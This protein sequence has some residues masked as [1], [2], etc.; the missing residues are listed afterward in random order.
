MANR[1]ARFPEATQPVVIADA[2]HRNVTHLE[3]QL[4]DAGVKNPIVK[5]QE[6]VSLQSFLSD[7]ASNEEPKPCVLFLDPRM[8]GANGY[9]PVRWIKGQPRLE[10][11]KVVIFSS[12][13]H[14]EEIESAGELGVHL[15]L[16]KN[17]DVSSLSVI[18]SHL[19]GMETAERQPWAAGT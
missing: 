8:P 19:C 2:D 11:I 7:V 12:T 14:P 17:P 10:G 6:G 18:V 5:F 15:F 9:N 13:N 16:M 4:R 1:Q 3:R